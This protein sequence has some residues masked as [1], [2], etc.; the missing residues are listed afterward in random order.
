VVVRAEYVI[1]VGPLRVAVDGAGDGE[2][3]ELFDGTPPDTARKLA[4][5]KAMILGAK[6]TWE[7][8]GEAL[9]AQL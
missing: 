2:F 7:A 3:A 4:E 9:R 1:D 8:E 6:L 5:H